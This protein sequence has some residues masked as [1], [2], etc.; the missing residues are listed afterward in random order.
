[1]KQTIKVGNAPNGIN[2]LRTDELFVLCQDTFGGTNGYVYKIGLQTYQILDSTLLGLKPGGQLEINTSGTSQELMFY[3][4]TSIYSFDPSNGFSNSE[5]RKA[6]YGS[7]LSS[8]YGIGIDESG[9]YW[10]A[11]H[12]GFTQNGLVVKANKENPQVI[13]NKYEVGIGP[14]GFLFL[15]N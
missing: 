15:G 7:E 2:A 3:S 5:N 11:D 10:I 4:G 9:N 1:V 8:I 13:V 12:R 6:E 14:N